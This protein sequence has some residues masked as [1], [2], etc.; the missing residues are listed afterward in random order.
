MHHFWRNGTT[1]ADT[2]TVRSAIGIEQAG[3]S[4]DRF[5]SR[6]NGP[7]FFGGADGPFGHGSVKVAGS[8]RASALQQDALNMGRGALGNPERRQRI[9]IPLFVSRGNTRV[10]IRSRSRARFNTRVPLSVS[11]CKLWQHA[12]R[13][14][15]TITCPL[16]HPC[17]PAVRFL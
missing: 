10:E 11:F 12:C 3:A 2:T 16:Q 1:T 13:N 5:A 9:G 7:G 8:S 4:A 15:F 14:S 17:T 6:E